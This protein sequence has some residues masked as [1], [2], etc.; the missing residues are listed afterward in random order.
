MEDIDFRTVEFEWDN[1]KS[2]RIK[3]I[4]GLSFDKIVEKI[5]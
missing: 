3:G 1:K 4:R 2:E 5:R